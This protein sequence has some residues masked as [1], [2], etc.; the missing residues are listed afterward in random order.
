MY[1]FKLKSNYLFLLLISFCTAHLFCETNKI[2]L[3]KSVEF[4]KKNRLDL[5]GF[6]YLICANWYDE[7]AALGGY[8]PQISILTESGKSSEPEPTG[9][10]ISPIPRESIAVDITQLIFSYDGP[11]VQYK[12]AQEETNIS[13]AQKET[14]Q[15][16]IR[17]STETSFL[18]AKKILLKKASIKSRDQSSQETFAQSKSRKKVGFFNKEQWKNAK[19]KYSEDQAHVKGYPDDVDT[20]ISILEREMSIDIEKQ[21]VSLEYK[22]L[23]E[24]EFKNVKFYKKRALLNRPELTELTHKIKQAEYSE[25]FYRY[26][27]IPEIY[28]NAVLQ[29]N[30]IYDCVPNEI[31]EA[32]P[33]FDNEP[34]FWHVGVKITWNFDGL[35]SFNTSRKFDNLS[36]NFL[37][38]KR[39]LELNIQKDVE[40]EYNTLGTLLITLDPMEKRYKAIKAKLENIKKQYDVGLAPFFKYKQAQFDYKQAEFDLIALKIDIKNSHQKLLFLCGYPPDIS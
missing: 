38:Q 40:V 3:D 11:L 23:D 24:I 18:E 30:R 19:F 21:D 35:S 12:I 9:G 29:K 4:A 28:F 34:F 26:K 37:L 33:I 31:Y 7:R 6:N 39:D 14:L 32:F 10:G 13:R 22:E 2:N 8:L 27:Y 20:A 5:E 17:I 25:K 15:R 16:L 36:T 1:K